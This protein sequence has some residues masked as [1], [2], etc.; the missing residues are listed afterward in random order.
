MRQRGWNFVYISPGFS[1][2]IK[3]SLFWSISLRSYDKQFLEGLSV[4]SRHKLN[5]H[6]MQGLPSTL[7]GH[8]FNLQTV[9]SEKLVT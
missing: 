3:H 5:N 8:N 1:R 4:L 9:S 6:V 2:S 7:K